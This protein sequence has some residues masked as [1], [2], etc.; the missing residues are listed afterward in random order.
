MSSCCLSGQDWRPAQAL[1]TPEEWR[2]WLL[3]R[4]S[5]TLKLQQDFPGTFRV[6]V[7]RHDWGIP[8]LDERQVLE[9]HDRTRASIR[10]VLL[11]CNDQPKVFARSILPVTSLQGRNRCLLQL[12]DRPLGE[13]LF[14]DPNLKRGEIEVSALAAR[15]FN[16]CLPFDYAD[17]VA[18]GRRSVFYLSN[19]PLLVSEFFLPDS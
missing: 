19:Q 1:T 12:K 17:Q 7:L 14:A 2:P 5:L 4:G 15:T 11:I 8:K 3:H 16:S 10:E 9:L 13:V 18:W 6:E